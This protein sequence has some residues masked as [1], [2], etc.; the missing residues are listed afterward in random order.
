MSVFDALI[1][2]QPVAELLQRAA[3]ASRIGD[4]ELPGPSPDSSTTADISS[5]AMAQAWLVTGPPGS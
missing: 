3:W 1:G 4:P 5:A 2:Q